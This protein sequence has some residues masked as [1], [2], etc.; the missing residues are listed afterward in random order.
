MF[1]SFKILRAAERHLLGGLIAET[2][3]RNIEATIEA[4]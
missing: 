1:S 4:I 2:R 3:M